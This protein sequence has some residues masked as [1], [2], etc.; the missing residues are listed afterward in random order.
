M[1]LELSVSIS[2]QTGGKIKISVIPIDAE[3]SGTRQKQQ[4][5]T[6]KVRL[7]PLLPLDEMRDLLSQDPA[8]QEAWKQI[9][10]GALTRNEDS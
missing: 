6:V 9:S 10:F 3:V 2:V 4:G 7:T 1:E 8:F 5:H